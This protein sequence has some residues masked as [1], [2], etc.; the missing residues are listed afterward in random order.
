M[1]YI[2]SGLP[3]TGKSTIAIRLAQHT[4]AT[5]L[6]IDTVEQGIRDVL[7]MAPEYEGYQLTHRIAGENL[8]IGNSAVVD[9]CNPLQITRT[10]WQSVAIQN[11]AAFVNIEIRCSD[12]AEHR[13]RIETRRSP[14]PNLQIPTWKQVKEREY[15]DW[16]EEHI[17]IDTAHCT[18]DQA[19]NTLLLKL[20]H[21]G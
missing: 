18:I 4:G 7:K 16:I 6:R 17:A 19:L 1:L 10:D 2:F 8:A 21:R 11:N 13:H 15:H 3:G 5:Y 20:R 9:S 12:E 14:I